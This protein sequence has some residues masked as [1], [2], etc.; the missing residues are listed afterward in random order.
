M[1]KFKKAKNDK[2]RVLDLCVTNVQ[3]LK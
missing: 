3:W 1:I 2:Q